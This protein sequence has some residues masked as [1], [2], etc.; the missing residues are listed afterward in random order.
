MSTAPASA[1]APPSF[2][3]VEGDAQ[4][5]QGADELGLLDAVQRLHDGQHQLVGLRLHRL[6]RRS[7][8][9][10]GTAFSSVAISDQT[11]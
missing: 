10:A 2:V 9:R 4:L 1:S 5:E 3:C 8:S 7:S 11:W 6:R